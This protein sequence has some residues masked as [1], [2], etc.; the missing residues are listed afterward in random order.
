MK[1]KLFSIFYLPRLP[2]FSGGGTLVKEGGK[3]EGG[4][5]SFEPDAKFEPRNLG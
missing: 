1:A 4:A 3:G 2:C 5:S